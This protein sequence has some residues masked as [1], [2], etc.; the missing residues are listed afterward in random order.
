MQ[1][2]PIQLHA[3]RAKHLRVPQRF[4][5]LQPF[6][7]HWALAT[8]TERNAQRHAMPMSEIT[9]FGT[10]MLGCVD[11]V[12]AYLNGFELGALAG[13]D[14]TLMVLLLS[15]AEVAP[16]IE[17]YRQPAVVDGY[18][19]ARFAADETFVMRPAI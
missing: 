15:F 19:P 11:E 5:A 1:Q 17:F 13:D 14:A 18:E 9:R 2:H 4:D 16:A 7:E 6:V 10:A 12:V 8:E 3:P